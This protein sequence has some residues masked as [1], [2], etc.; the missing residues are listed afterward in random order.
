MEERNANGGAQC[1]EGGMVAPLTWG[2]PKAMQSECT[3]SLPKHG[4]FRLRVRAE[5]TGSV[6]SPW[7]GAISSHEELDQQAPGRQSTASD[8][9]R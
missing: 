7:A 5:R 9:P 6:F 4:T 8:K 1:D 2:W 3:S